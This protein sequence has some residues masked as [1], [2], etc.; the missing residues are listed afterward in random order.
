M[1]AKVPA[2]I[3]VKENT[4]EVIISRSSDRKDSKTILFFQFF[5][6][7]ILFLINFVTHIIESIVSFNMPVDLLFGTEVPVAIVA[8]RVDM[9]FAFVNL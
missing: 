2:L 1:A 4:W 9:D 8:L 6:L 5:Q 7:K 3:T